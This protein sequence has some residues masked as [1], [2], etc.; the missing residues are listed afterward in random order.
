MPALRTRDTQSR[1]LEVTTDAP[2]LPTVSI[3]SPTPRAFTFPAVHGPPP[4][5]PHSPFSSPSHS[6]FEADLPT[7]TSQCTTS[8]SL[9]FS[10]TLSPD[11]TL[12]SSSPSP[13]MQSQHKRRK[14][15]ISSDVERRPKRGDEDYIKRPENAFIL[16][17][18]KCCEDRQAQEENSS[19]SPVKKQRQAD[20]SKAISQQWKNL[21]TEERQYWEQ[22][23][24][25]KK[26][27][28]EQMY[29]NYVYRPQ[30][31]R[32]KDGRAKI[33]KPTSISKNRRGADLEHE[34]DTESLSFVV[35]MAPLRHHGRSASAP[36]PPPYQSIQV[37]NVYHMT[38]S[39]PTSPSLLPMISRRQSVAGLEESQACVRDSLLAPPALFGSSQQQ[40]GQ[41]DAADMSTNFLRN[42]YSMGAAQQHVSIPRNEAMNLQP[43]TLPHDN[44]LLP[45]QLISPA[46]A[47]SSPDSASFSP[48]SALLAHSFAQ[49]STLS[50][51]STTNNTTGDQSGIDA[52]PSSEQPPASLNIPN[53]VANY[54]LAQPHQ[55]TDFS[56]FNWDD[57]TS[58]SSSTN[59]TTSLW[60]SSPDT[61]LTNDDFDLRSIPPV[62]LELP[63][64]TDDLGFGA[65]FHAGSG[66]SFGQDFAHALEGSAGG[67][68]FESHHHHHHHHLQHHPDT[69]LDNLL[70]FE[71]MMAGHG[72]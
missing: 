4:L 71:E 44:L 52:S 70:L 13:S 46:S 15:S 21:S 63:K 47:A 69:H 10:R 45:P 39:C 31:S 25:E 54:P 37:P 67:R 3:I 32:D 8:S 11:S 64:Y 40:P 34:T 18:R 55:P 60:S 30:R 56:P 38:P 49:L 12:K 27:E 23:A 41:Y 6:P 5:L 33:K 17:R 58:S 57:P 36:T 28:H 62:E 22:L 59:N 35:P 66:L 48:A 14:S 20:L 16:F 68:I 1:S 61:L 26:K 9:T 19:D 72:F 53:L 42:L 24:K 65:A 43:L 2:Q 29:P 51:T 7:L 50:A